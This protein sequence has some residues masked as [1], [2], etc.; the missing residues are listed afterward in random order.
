MIY[1]FKK[2]EVGRMDVFKLACT[3]VKMAKLTSCRLCEGF[4]DLWLSGTSSPVSC[5]E[6]LAPVAPQCMAA[7]C[8]NSSSVQSQEE[9]LPFEDKG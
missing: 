3:Q 5:Q 9:I 6:P 4:L 2:T 8:S 7:L 1:F